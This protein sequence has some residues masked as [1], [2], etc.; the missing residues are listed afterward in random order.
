MSVF[1]QSK[2]PPR[3]PGKNYPGDECSSDMI[4]VNVT[5]AQR[6]NNDDRIAFSPMTPIPGSYHGFY[7]FENFWQSGKR[8][9]ELGHLDSTEKLADIAVWKGYQEPHRRHPKAKGLRP[10]DAVY[11]DIGISNGL[12]YID[13]RKQVY[14]P[15]YYNDILT[16]QP[17][18]RERLKHYQELLKQGHNILVLDYDGPKLDPGTDDHIVF[19]RPCLKVTVELLKE[20]INDPRF[21]FGHGYVVAAAILGI[22]PDEYVTTEVKAKPVAPVNKI[23]A[24]IQWS[25]KK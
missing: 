10:V 1:I 20:K 9:Q 18:G 11:P 21:Q 2:I 16:G 5:S 13:S 22:T 24:K 8:Y 3:Q 6:K 12:T 23:K 14:V 15:Y 19:T 17:A 25:L 7:C 4:K